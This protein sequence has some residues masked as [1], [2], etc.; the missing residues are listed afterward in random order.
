MN[1][2]S[3]KPIHPESQASDAGCV[4]AYVRPELLV[5]PK[6]LAEAPTSF[7]VLDTRAKEKFDAGH[8][9]HARWVDHDG[10][11][12]HFGDGSDAAGWS[13]RLGAL[14]IDG[15]T[16][17]VVYDDDYRRSGRIWWLLRYWGVPDVRLLNGGWHA[18]Q[19][20]GF[21]SAARA[22][23]A[24]RVEFT[25]RPQRRLLAT[26][27][28]VLSCLANGTMQIVDARGEK[29]YRGE[30]KMKN[31]HGGAI[32]GAKHLDWNELIDES[33]KKFKP[34]AALRERFEQKTIA[35]DY[36]TATHCQSGARASVMMFAME[37]LGASDVRN[38]YASWHE[39]G[40][41][42][43]TPIARGPAP[44]PRMSGDVSPG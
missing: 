40:N 28:D 36:P 18:W 43:D 6:S 5:E 10:W 35:L 27:D 4:L 9:P 38:Y 20:E 11:Q 31:K 7:V 23:E 17:V 24:T 19:A 16:P 30:E 22:E 12:K 44:D 1:L 32:P 42:D 39:W 33:T 3:S 34:A 14:G 8:A 21:A 13:E 15:S 2:F 37:L 29:E 25:A 41:R 26:M